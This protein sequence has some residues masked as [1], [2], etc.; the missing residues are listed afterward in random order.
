MDEAA[1]RFIV[2]ESITIRLIANRLNEGMCGSILRRNRQ[3]HS[4]N[5]FS[6][7]LEI[8]ISDASEF[9]DHPVKGVQVGDY[10]IPRTQSAATKCHCCH[11]LYTN[12][13]GKLPHAYFGWGEGNPI[14]YA[15][16]YL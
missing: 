9:V 12:Q 10:R 13:T 14:F 6:S 2:E 3:P 11:P 4:T 16:S 1:R 15:S 8:Q 7:V 5:R